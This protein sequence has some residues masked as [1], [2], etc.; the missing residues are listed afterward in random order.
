M[1]YEHNIYV[2][3][4][5]L[6]MLTYKY[7]TDYD[8][9]AVHISENEIVGVGKLLYNE[10]KLIDNN[11]NELDINVYLPSHT[12]MAVNDLYNKISGLYETLMAM[13]Q[14]Q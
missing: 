10:S 12:D 6:G 14:Q 9:S 5:E 13:I 1:T 4:D 11:G 7:Y 2:P 3:N 8:P